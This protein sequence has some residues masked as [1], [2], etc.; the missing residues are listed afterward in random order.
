MI[1]NKN[2]NSQYILIEIPHISTSILIETCI[3]N[4]C[5]SCTLSHVL[6]VVGYIF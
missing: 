5:M 3:V 4:T 2:M 6:E 1:T